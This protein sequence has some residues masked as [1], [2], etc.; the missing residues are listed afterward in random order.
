[1][2]K[3]DRD[4]SYIFIELHLNKFS[5][6]LRRATIWRECKHKNKYLTDVFELK[7]DDSGAFLYRGAILCEKETGLFRSLD[8]FLLFFRKKYKYEL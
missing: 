4:Q 2:R 8:K 3:I 5:K 6:Y 1:M 7:F